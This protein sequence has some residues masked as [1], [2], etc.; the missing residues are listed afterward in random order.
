MKSLVL[1]AAAVVTLVAA[2]VLFWPSGPEPS[3]ASQKRASSNVPS[4]TDLTAEGLRRLV[5]F[6]HSMPEGGGASDRSR[7]YPVLVAEATGLRLVDRAEGGTIA[8][9]AAV[10]MESSPPVSEGDVVVIHTG[11]N[12][13]FRRGAEAAEIGREAI[14]RL[15]S[16]TADASRRVVV[17]EC[18]PTSWLDTPPGIDLQA[19][20]EAWNAMVA[21]EVAASSDVALLDTCATWEPDSYTD[22]AKYHP[23]DDG[24]ALIA[25]ELTA[26]LL[27]S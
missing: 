18:Q 19:A 4:A 17:L 5:V 26:A 25:R 23:N 6:G 2:F 12:D 14:S 27:T 24:H 1:G 11:M 10:A 15:L 8:A 13:I 21:E 7:A 3:A 20:Y 22:A 9:T 16:G